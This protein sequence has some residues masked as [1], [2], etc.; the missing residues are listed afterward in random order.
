MP[1]QDGKKT[2]SYIV[3]H[4][5]KNEIQKIYSN[6]KRQQARK[7]NCHVNI[8]KYGDDFLKEKLKE[9]RL[10]CD[11]QYRIAQRTGN[12]EAFQQWIE[13]TKFLKR[14][15]EELYQKEKETKSSP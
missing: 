15:L 1:H 10:E 11:K 9:W 7:C 2:C 6:I 8:I 14:R 12:K 4:L 5:P 3:H 13:D